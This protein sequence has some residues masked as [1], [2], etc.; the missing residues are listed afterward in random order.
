MAGCRTTGRCQLLLPLVLVAVHCS[1]ALLLRG[2]IST[3]DAA[4]K[5]PAAGRERSSALRRASAAVMVHPGPV[6]IMLHVYTAPACSALLGAGSELARLLGLRPSRTVRLP[7]WGLAGSRAA[8]VSSLSHCARGGAWSPAAGDTGRKLAL[9]VLNHVVRGRPQIEKSWLIVWL[10]WR[11]HLQ[12][13]S[14]EETPRGFA[15]AAPL[16]RHR[17]CRLLKACSD[18]CAV[19]G[20]GRCWLQG[21][22]GRGITPPPCNHTPPAPLFL[23][24]LLVPGHVAPSHGV[25]SGVCRRSNSSFCLWGR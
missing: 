25:T 6:V 13:A 4:R 18:R 23:C 8:P 3:A 19:E 17:G 9:K 12:P 5:R 16:V 22:P 10:Y 1:S 2:C 7:L 14:R 20:G 11:A 15:R 21:R 24:L